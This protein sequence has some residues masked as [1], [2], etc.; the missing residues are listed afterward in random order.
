MCGDGWGSCPE[1]GAIE[2]LYDND[3]K[4]DVIIF[5]DRTE[6]SDFYKSLDCDKAAWNITRGLELI[7]CHA[8]MEEDNYDNEDLPF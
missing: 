8:L 3:G 4:E 6:A 1:H 5:N 2:V 7:E